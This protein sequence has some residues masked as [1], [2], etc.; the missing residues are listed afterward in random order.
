LLLAFT[1]SQL[2]LLLLLLLLCMANTCR[3]APYNKAYIHHISP[4]YRIY[5]RT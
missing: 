5:Y 3:M 2:L 1:C 4:N